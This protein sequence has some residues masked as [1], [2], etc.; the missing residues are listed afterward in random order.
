MH[1][2]VQQMTSLPVSVS[3]LGIGIARHQSIGYWVLGAKPGIVLTLRLTLSSQAVCP[4][5][6]TMAAGKLVAKDL[7]MWKGN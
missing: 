5:P 1:L 2:S 6:L 4:W 7:G 3:V